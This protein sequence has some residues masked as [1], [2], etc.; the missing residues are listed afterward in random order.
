[1][2][3]RIITLPNRRAQIKMTEEEVMEYL[4][5]ESV[6]ILGTS[7]SSGAPHLVPMGYIMVGVN[8]AVWS[9]PKSQKIMNLRR[10]PRVS[11]LVHGGSSYGDFRGVEMVGAARLIEDFDEVLAI[12]MAMAA[13]HRIAAGDTIAESE[14]PE[15][16]RAQAA[17]RVAVEIQ[18]EQIVSWDHSK[19]GG[20]Y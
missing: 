16:V 3:E 20:V 19:L 9:F 12:G 10:D 13:R 2:S 11:A 4:E 1:M 8:P 5:Q 18:V 7:T 15:F 14:E 6:L 17:K